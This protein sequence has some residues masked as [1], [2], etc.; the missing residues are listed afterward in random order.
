MIKVRLSVQGKMDQK[1]QLKFGSSSIQLSN[2]F[3]TI[4]FSSG[5]ALTST[6]HDPFFLLFIVAPP[7]NITILYLLQFPVQ[8]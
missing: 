1:A 5:H 7:L 8:K 2:E 6:I 3:D 4:L